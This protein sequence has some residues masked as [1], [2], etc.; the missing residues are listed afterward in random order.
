LNKIDWNLKLAQGDINNLW[1]RF[2]D[3]LTI[4]YEENIPENSVNHA[5]FIREN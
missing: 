2:A 1:Q 5:L 3:E 4:I